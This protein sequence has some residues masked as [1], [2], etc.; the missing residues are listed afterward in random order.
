MLILLKIQTTSSWPV[1]LFTT[2][3]L[4][5]RKSFVISCEYLPKFVSL[6]Q[7]QSRSLLAIVVIYEMSKC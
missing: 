4:Q 1:I 7:R 3:H 6:G 2:K 5:N